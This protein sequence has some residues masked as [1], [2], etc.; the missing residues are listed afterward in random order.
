MVTMATTSFTIMTCPADGRSGVMQDV[1]AVLPHLS[2]RR[3]KQRDTQLR[4]MSLLCCVAL[5]G[6]E[7]REKGDSSPILFMTGNP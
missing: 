7:L 2:E 5:E 1:T 6:D 3:D 4:V